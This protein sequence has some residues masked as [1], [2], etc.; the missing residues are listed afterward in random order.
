MNIGVFDSGLGG[1]SVF[2]QFLKYLPEYNYIYLGD[3]KRAPYGGYSKQIIYE[4]TKQAVEKLFKLNCG[5][6]ILACNTA[7]AA[8]LH[9]LQQTYLP[10]HY[11]DRRILGVI[12]P[13][14][15]AAVE[16]NSKRIGILATQATVDSKSFLHE[17]FKF[18]PAIKAFQKAAPLLVPKIESGELASL[19]LEK[20]IKEYTKPLLKHNIDSLLLGCTHYELIKDVIAKHIGPNIHII[21]EGKVTAKKLKDYLKRHSKIEKLLQKSSHVDIFTTHVTPHYEKL[22][23]LF[24]E[25]YITP[26]PP[27]KQITL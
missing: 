15:E 7:T 18:S 4:Y 1:L 20:L 17:L 9:D 13:G 22:V 12:R 6:V 8:A 24:L 2:R 3:N 16:Q 23:D 11:P 19:E 14:I 10:H 5:L 27:L 25:D 21:A 26:I